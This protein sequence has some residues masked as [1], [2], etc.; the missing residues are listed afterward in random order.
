MSKGPQAGQSGC[1]W[2]DSLD[3]EALDLG[4]RVEGDPN[5]ALSSPFTG[6]LQPGLF[7]GLW[8]RAGGR[9][10]KLF[11]SRSWLD[12]GTNPRTA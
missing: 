1:R 7:R 5:K 2:G 3:S 4:G 6:A 10:G 9:K 11:G 12:V 8:G